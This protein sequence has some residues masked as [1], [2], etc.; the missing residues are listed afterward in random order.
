MGGGMASATDKIGLAGAAVGFAEE[1]QHR[2]SMSFRSLTFLVAALV[3]ALDL[4]AGGAAEG[5]GLQVGQIFRDCS[6]LI[7][8]TVQLIDIGH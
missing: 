3:A 2:K 7:T 8:V 6:G 1:P 5:Q 4:P